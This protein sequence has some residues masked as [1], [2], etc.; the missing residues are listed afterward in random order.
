MFYYNSTSKT[1]HVIPA[2]PWSQW[3]VII[4]CISR[5]DKPD[6]TH[7]SKGTVNSQISAVKLIFQGKYNTEKIRHLK[8][9]SCFSAR[10]VGGF[11]SSLHLFSLL[12]D[13]SLFHWRLEPCFGFVFFFLSLLLV[14]VCL[15]Q[16]ESSGISYNLLDLF[17]FFFF[18]SQKILLWSL[19]Q[20][21][22]RTD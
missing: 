4:E 16:I 21:T 17:F 12:S 11:G 3:A 1:I 2:V 10:E 9:S 15:Q 22:A 14:V 8:Y 20:S 19:C 13:D 5:C 18:N 7:L 6:Y